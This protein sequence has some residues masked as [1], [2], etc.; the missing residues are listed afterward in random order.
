MHNGLVFLRE[1][2]IHGGSARC[3]DRS[4][5]TRC[6]T[7]LLQF[8]ELFRLGIW[9][10]FQQFFE[11]I[12]I[13]S[14]SSFFQII[15]RQQGGDLFTNCQGNELVHGDTFLLGH[16]LQAFVQGFGKSNA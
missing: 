12:P 8:I 1:G 13:P 9:Y 2:N 3:Q 6:Y 7:P 5:R 16:F 15:D 14:L 10:L 11:G 4:A